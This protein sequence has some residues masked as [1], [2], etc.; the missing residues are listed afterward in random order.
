MKRITTTN[1]ESTTP[2]DALVSGIDSSARNT[3][4]P[5][6]INAVKNEV[7]DLNTLINIPRIPVGR[8][9][10][11]LIASSVS[12]LCSIIPEYLAGHMLL[13]R[14]KP[15]SETHFL[16]FVRLVKGIKRDFVHVLKL[17]FR[18]TS[19]M[20]TNYHDGTADFYPSYKVGMIPYRSLL[21]PVDEVQITDSRITDFSTP[22]INLEEW[23]GGDVHSLTH[24]IFDEFDPTPINEKI[25]DSAGRDLFPFSIRLYPV[26]S[27]SYF[28][29]SLSIPCPTADELTAAVRIFEP[30]CEKIIR[31]FSG[32]EASA[33]ASE[34][35]PDALKNSAGRISY[36]GQFSDEA[37]NYFS[38]ITLSQNDELA[39]KRW[40]RLD[41][42]F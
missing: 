2:I 28:S 8:I 16:H 19:E 39:L 18:F 30:M 11:P 24:T 6:F 36:T 23:V 1:D 21:V 9:S 42:A 40:R 14:Q 29:V 13:P 33:E 38:R 32:A 37:R 25:A 10:Y 41:V 3:C 22:R 26:L 15:P 31:S 35:Y 12:E 34:S 27:Y 17:D 7:L 4:G 20:G 5:V